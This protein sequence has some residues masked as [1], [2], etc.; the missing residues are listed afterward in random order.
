VSAKYL[1]ID[2]QIRSLNLSGK[3]A[4]AIVLCTGDNPGQ[5]NQLFKAFLKSHSDTMNVNIKAFNTAI[6]KAQQ[7]LD[8]SNPQDAISDSK[9]VK[10]NVLFDI[11]WLKVFLVT[12]LVAGLTYYGLMQRIKEYEV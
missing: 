5:S 6:K 12:G 7:S 11:F 4:E 9:K 1:S 10:E 8:V 3:R 2:S